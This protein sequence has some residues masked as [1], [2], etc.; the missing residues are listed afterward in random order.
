MPRSSVGSVLASLSERRNRY[1][2]YSLARH[3]GTAPMELEVLAREVAAWERDVSSESVSD[4]AFEAVLA[5]LSRTRLPTLSRRDL[6]EYDPLS[7]L[8]G[9]P[10]YSVPAEALVD[11]LA[12][13]ELASQFCNA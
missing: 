13:T 6:V 3:A 8:V 11:L 10:R 12:R 9:R 1:V 5:D 2:L 4:E 7:G